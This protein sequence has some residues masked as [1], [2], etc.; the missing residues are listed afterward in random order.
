MVTQRPRVLEEVE[1]ILH[2]MVLRNR[3]RQE[4]STKQQALEAWRQVTEVLLTACPEDLLTT[5]D[6]QTVLFELLQELQRKVTED[7]ALT[8]L[9]APVAGIILTLMTNLRQCFCQDSVTDDEASH[10]LTMLD[11]TAGQGQ[12]GSWGQVSGSQTQFA[13]SLQLVLR[14]VI[15]H[16][17]LSSGGQQRVRANLYGALLSETQFT[18]SHRYRGRR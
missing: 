17:L 3:I 13:S 11:S 12:M 18:D 16:I 9:T 1:N 14:G 7:D 5:E 8:E 15:D 10:F 4:L 2:H 6:R